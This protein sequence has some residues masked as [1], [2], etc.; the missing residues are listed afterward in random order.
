MAKLLM[1]IHP[2]DYDHYISE[3]Y[4][5]G[6]KAYDA[7]EL[8]KVSDLRQSRRLVC[9]PLKAVIKAWTT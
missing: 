1:D 8:Y 4:G 2:Y 9:E 6:L 7:F 3:A 5:G